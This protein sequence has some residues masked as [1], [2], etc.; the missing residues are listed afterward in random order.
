MKCLTDSDVLVILCN[1]FIL[2]VDRYSPG[3]EFLFGGRG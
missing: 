3:D 1:Q 2:N